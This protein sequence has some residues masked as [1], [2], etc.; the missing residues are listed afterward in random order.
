MCSCLSCVACP[1]LCVVVSFCIVDGCVM[2]E[3]NGCCLLVVGGCAVSV[4][5]VGYV[6]CALCVDCCL[7]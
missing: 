6:F 4:V 5:V 2:C 3:I 1:L 7:L